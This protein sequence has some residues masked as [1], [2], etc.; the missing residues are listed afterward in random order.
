MTQQAPFPTPV[1]TAESAEFWAGCQRGELL[2]QK[3]S[4]CGTLRYF[5]RAGCPR[6]T[7][8]QYTWH[9]VSGRGTLYSFIVVHP[10]TLPAFKDKVPYPV[11]LVE[12]EEG[13]RMIS[14]IVDCK[15]EELRIGMPLEVV[16]DRINEDL[17]L[18]K[19]RPARKK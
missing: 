19:F 18:P 17:T 6:C 12:L 2:I 16:F 3:C 13:V 10:P 11:I 7:S 5:P 14:N 8:E 15:N 4:Q 1:P 9:K